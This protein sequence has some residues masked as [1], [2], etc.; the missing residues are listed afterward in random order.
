M[1]DL[2]TGEFHPIP[3]E[4]IDQFATEQKLA[5]WEI[6]QGAKD[7]VI[8]ELE[9]QGPTF[10]CGEELEVKGGKFK[11]H[12]IAGKRLYLDSLPSK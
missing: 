4:F 6:A 12:A 3:Q 2:R 9:Y 7:K 8:P 10:F 5:P 11:V 1:Q